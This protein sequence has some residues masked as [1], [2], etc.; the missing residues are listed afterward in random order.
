[1]Q[2]G[3]RTWG[4]HLLQQHQHLSHFSEALRQKLSEAQQRCSHLWEDSSPLT[5]TYRGERRG[6][7]KEKRGRER[8]ER[9]WGDGREGERGRERTG[10][11]S[12]FTN[13][14]VTTKL[15]EQLQMIT[16]LAVCRALSSS[17]VFIFPSFLSRYFEYT[18]RGPVWAVT[19]I[20]P[21]SSNTL[22]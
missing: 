19:K 1:M 13:N 16:K 8:G 12:L 11:K 15:G 7:E 18:K 14:G 4:H 20:L 3:A 2:A 21:A 10:H 5:C 17:V 22:S 6:R 9:E